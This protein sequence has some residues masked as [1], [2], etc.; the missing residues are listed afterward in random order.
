LFYEIRIQR[1]QIFLG[2]ITS[3]LYLDL[4]IGDIG[5]TS[6][7]RFTG[8]GLHPGWVPPRSDLGQTTYPCVP[9]SPAILSSI[10]W[11]QPKRS[12]DL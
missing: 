2:F 9:L 1:M 12:D 11:Y 3:L 7:L 4:C 8:R 10:I 6:D 5:R